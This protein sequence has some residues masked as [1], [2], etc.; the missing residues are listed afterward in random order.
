MHM[1]F[2][3]ST[4]KLP[5]NSFYLADPKNYVDQCND[6]NNAITGENNENDKVTFVKQT[7][8]HRRDR[9]ARML[10]N[11]TPTIEIDADVL[12]NYPSFTVDINIDETDRNIKEEEVFDKIINQ[13]PPDNDTIYIEHNKKNNKYRVRRET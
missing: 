12:E 3:I 13:L 4:P 7:P 5:R 10:K 1:I 2:L 6:S 11:K 9:L 8:Q